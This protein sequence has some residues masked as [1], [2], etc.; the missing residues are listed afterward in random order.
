MFGVPFVGYLVVAWFL[1][2]RYASYNGDAQARLANAY[3]VLFSRDP[4]LAAIGFVWNP[5]PSLSVMP[6]LPLKVLWPALTTQAFAGNIMSA[7]FMAGAGFQIYGFFRDIG[8]RRLMRLLFTAVFVLNPMIFYY[9]GNGMSEGIFIFTLVIATRYLARWLAE[10]RGLW[11]VISAGALGLAYL[12][13][14]EAAFAAFFAALVVVVVSFIRSKS[15]RHERTYKALTDAFI[16]SLPFAVCFVGWAIVSWLIVGHPFEQ[17]QSVYGTASQLRVINAGNPV[18][19]S[20]SE[21]ASRALHA[22]NALAPALPVFAVVALVLALRRKDL[23]VLAPLAMLGGVLLFAILAYSAGQTAGWFRY[24]IMAV[25]L[26]IMLSGA[27]LAGLWP[28]GA[29]PPKAPTAIRRWAPTMLRVA[30]SILVIAGVAAGVPSTTRALLHSTVASEEQ[31]HLDY[32]VNPHPGNAAEAAEQHRY[33]TTVAIA[34][35][36]DALNLRHGALVVDNFTPCVPYIVLS[37]RHPQQFIIPNDQDF[38]PSLADPVTFHVQY[39][40]APTLR[41]YGTLDAVNREYPTLH[42][43]GAG[44]S[45]FV[46][47]F[48]MPGCPELSLFRINLAGPS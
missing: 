14:N 10:D 33:A 6:L 40:M 42:E 47:S 18:H 19:L 11:L 41:G 20:H 32:I 21:A 4:H 17:F 8:T 5:L 46:R 45:T 25:P 39:L 48:S 37:S 1:V 23:R 9:G 44:I 27:I 31:L 22:A 34:R 36:I 26:V 24:Y 13:R 35:A 3:Y 12:A 28:K 43:N 15:D 30:S 16:F 2:F 38:Q 29:K 7:V